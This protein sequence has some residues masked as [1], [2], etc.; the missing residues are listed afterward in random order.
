MN[1][2]ALIKSILTGSK[3]PFVSWSAGFLQV[4]PLEAIEPRNYQYLVV[5]I[6]AMGDEFNWPGNHRGHVLKETNKN[7]SIEQME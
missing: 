5:A 2:D 3:Q 7:Y 1:N 6:D 4:V